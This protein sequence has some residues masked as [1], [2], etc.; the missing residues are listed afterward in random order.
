MVE[1]RV[2][3][4]RRIAQLLA[5][6]IRGRERG[7]LGRLA[8]VDVRDVEGDA[9]GEFAFG[10]AAGDRR[11]ADVYVHED[12]ARAEFR[13]APDAAADAGRRAG[14]RTRPKAVHPPRTVVFLEDGVAAKRALPVF[15]TVVEALDATSG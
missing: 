15:R 12:R 6:E 10:V 7:P 14:L 5:S 3:D 9:F 4:G 1:D 2:T 13:G 11:V 8:V